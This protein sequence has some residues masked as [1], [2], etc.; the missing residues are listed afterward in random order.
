MH[1][2]WYTEPEQTCI[3]SGTREHE[4]TCIRSGIREPEQ[5]CIR[6]GTRVHEQTCIRSCIREPEQTC[7]RFG[8]REPEQTCIRSGTRE[9]EQIRIMFGRRVPTASD[10]RKAGSKMHTAC[11]KICR[12]THTTHMHHVCYKKR[13]VTYVRVCSRSATRKAE[14]TIDHAEHTHLN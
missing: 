5:T 12:A 1:Q 6:S 11:Q 8:I 14:S 7:I 2:V 9:H 10:T 4:Q 13:L 3:R